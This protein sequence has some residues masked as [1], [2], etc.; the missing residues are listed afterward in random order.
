ME[1]LEKNIHKVTSMLDGNTI[2]KL[3]S[4]KTRLN[5]FLYKTEIAIAGVVFLISNRSNYWVHFV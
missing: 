1:I 5:N 4:I 2:C 3:Y